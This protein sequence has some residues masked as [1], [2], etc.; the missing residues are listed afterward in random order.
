MDILAKQIDSKTAWLVW[1]I[2]VILSY[3]W[4]GYIYG[5][6]GHVCPVAFLGMWNASLIGIVAWKNSRP[7]FIATIA[8]L[9]VTAICFAFAYF[10]LHPIDDDNL[11]RTITIGPFLVLA[12]CPILA[13]LC[14]KLLLLG[15]ERGSTKIEILFEQFFGI[16]A[17]LGGLL[18]GIAYFIV[19]SIKIA[20][21]ND[22]TTEWFDTLFYPGDVWYLFGV[23]MIIALIS[24]VCMIINWILNRRNL[25]SKSIG[26][27]ILGYTFLGFV[28]IGTWCSFVYLGK[29]KE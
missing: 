7:R 20:T 8:S 1:I 11:T 10:I 22:D 14:Q 3:A 21:W 18:A 12:I 13:L 4:F 27:R 23:L 6:L 24:A 9:I 29:S 19:P 25:R 17:G 5:I 2:Q 16:I 26:F 28:L 15:P